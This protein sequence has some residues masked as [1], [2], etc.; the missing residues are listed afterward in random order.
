MKTYF[1]DYSINYRFLTK[2]EKVWEKFNLHHEKVEELGD[3]EAMYRLEG[4]QKDLLRF[5]ISSGD[6]K[7]FALSQIELME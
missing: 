7:S 6:S 2:L 1:T 4:S 5:L 3:G